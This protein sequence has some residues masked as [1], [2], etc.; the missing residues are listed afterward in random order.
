MQCRYLH[1]EPSGSR[2]ALS[3]VRWESFLIMHD[4]R[5]S[6][7]DLRRLMR[8]RRQ[9]LSEDDRAQAA[10]SLTQHALA[11]EAWQGA[12]KIALYLANDAEADPSLLAKALRHAGKTPFLPVIQQDNSLRFAPWVESSELRDNRFGIPEPQTPAIRAEE[13]DIIVLPL[14]AWDIQGNRLG[15]GGG[16]YDRSL[17][18]AY[19][20]LKVGLAY[21]LQRVETLP[22][23]PWDI[24]LNFVATEAA[25]VQCQGKN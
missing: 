7:P 17:S 10:L 21:E 6:K 25:L 9:A 15:M 8:Q 19:D 3:A 20:V 1:L 24:R 4:T 12:S 5:Q 16:F 18:G 2:A 22:T 14:V 23:E 13:L 11:L